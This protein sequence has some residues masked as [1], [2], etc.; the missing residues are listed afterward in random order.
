MMYNYWLLFG[1][2]VVGPLLHSTWDSLI[3][4]CFIKHMRIL[5]RLKTICIGQNRSYDRQ[6]ILDH[7][8]S[9][10]VSMAMHR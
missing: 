3:S 8:E 6:T 7:V 10:I 2:V 5:T 9:G 1:H 4:H